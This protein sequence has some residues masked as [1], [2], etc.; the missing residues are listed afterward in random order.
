M[1]NKKHFCWR[2][3]RS[4]PRFQK[5]KSINSKVRFYKRLTLVMSDSFCGV[6]RVDQEPLSNYTKMTFFETNKQ[7]VTP[8]SSCAK[9][10]NTPGQQ[11]RIMT[12]PTDEFVICPWCNGLSNSEP[13]ITCGVCGCAGVIPKT[14]VTRIP[15]GPTGDEMFCACGCG[16]DDSRCDYW[17][18]QYQ[19]K[20]EVCDEHRCCKTLVE[21]NLRPCNLNGD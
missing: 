6:D 21:G 8:Y 17:C 18:K 3:P 5:Q 11:R 10:T 12:T 19:Q 14:E 1:R 2:V 16:G 15:C 20:K 4:S 7:S 13:S 9:L